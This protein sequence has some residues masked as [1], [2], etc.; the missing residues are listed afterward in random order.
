MKKNLL[1]QR[2]LTVGGGQT[3]LKCD[4]ANINV[5]IVNTD[6]LKSSLEPEK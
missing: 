3:V 6:K 5:N 4:V 2:M 1:S